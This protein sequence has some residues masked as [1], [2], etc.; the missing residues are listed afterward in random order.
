MEYQQA[1]DIRKRGLFSSI[2][3]KLVSGQGIGSS[4]GSAI[5]E[6]TQATVQGIKEKFDVLNIAKTLTGGSKFAPALLGRMLGRK[7]SDIEYFTGSKSKKI[8]SNNIAQTNEMTVDVLGLIYREMLRTE[9]QRKIDFA[10][11]EEEKNKEIEL[12]NTR[13]KEIIAALT[14][15]KKK[16]QY[17]RDE[18]GRFVKKDKTITT[19]NKPKGMNVPKTRTTSTTPDGITKTA[20]KSLPISPASS[21]T[22][23]VA[24]GAILGAAGISAAAAISIRGETGKTATSKQDILDKAG[25]VVP[26]DPKPGVTS[27]GIFGMNSGSGTVQQFL[28]ENPQ[29]AITAKPATPEFDKQWKEVAKQ[30]GPE[31]LDAQLMWH[32][33]HIL[34]PLRKELANKLPQGVRPNEQVLAYMADRRIQYGKVQEQSALQ[35]ASGAKTPVEW[36]EKMTEYDL[37]NLGTAFSTYLKQHPE[38]KKGL[39]NRLEMRK[40][41]AL[42]VSPDNNTGNQIEQSSKE[43]RDAKLKTDSS[44]VQQKNVNTTNVRNSSQSIP[45][46]EP[47]DDRSAYDIKV[48]KR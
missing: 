11:G 42:S 45:Q 10:D 5:S 23:K 13:N 15:R 38:A 8:Q 43:N 22:S 30:R 39:I 25:Q 4:V 7:K 31:F 29:F 2:T 17:A 28:A 33:K 36:I 21:T 14:G 26:N 46:S 32:D 16:K 34:H 41:M 47:E 18:K 3:D 6:K 35:Y 12:E 37:S 24:G 44:A 40:S 9:E 1:A 48:K 27:Y 20:P 19:E